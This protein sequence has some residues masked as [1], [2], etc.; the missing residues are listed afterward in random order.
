MA[1]ARLPYRP[2]NRRPPARPLPVPT[3]NRS[4]LPPSPVPDAAPG[5]ERRRP[6]CYF[7]ALPPG[8]RPRRPDA[9]SP[10]CVHTCAGPRQRRFSS[11]LDA[12][13]KFLLPCFRR[14]HGAPLPCSTSTLAAF[15]V[16]GPLPAGAPSSRYAGLLLPTPPSSHCAAPLVLPFPVRAWVAAPVFVAHCPRRRRRTLP[17]PGGPAFLALPALAVPCSVRPHSS[18]APAVF[19]RPQGLL[20]F[21]HNVGING[22]RLT[23]GAGSRAPRLDAMARRDWN[24]CW[25]PACFLAVALMAA[26]L[27]AVAD[28]A[29]AVEG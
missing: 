21:L 2:W 23:M 9:S 15:P 3:Q 8:L 11:S 24:P 5:A 29:A 18:P 7:P 20:L 6:I 26:S 28:S 19:P 10:A 27:R 14:L 4:G 17:L 22:D 1:P 16:A 13:R 25:Y 12:C